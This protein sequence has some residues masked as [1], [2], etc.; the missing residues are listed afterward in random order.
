MNLWLMIFGGALAL[1][2]GAAHIFPTRSLV[3]GKMGQPMNRRSARCVDRAAVTPPIFA[4]A[5]DRCGSPVAPL[6]SRFRF[7]RPAASDT[8]P[9]E[10]VG[11]EQDRSRSRTD[12]LS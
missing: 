1:I 11:P 8:K 4:S 3:A 2:W 5:N 12:P 9:L 7:V 10:N 6:N